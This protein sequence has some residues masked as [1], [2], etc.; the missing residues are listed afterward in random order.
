MKRILL[1]FIAVMALSL[2]TFA[3]LWITQNTNLAESRGITYMFSVNA[4]IVWAAAYDGVT[5]T[6]PCQDF[7]KTLDGGNTWTPGTITGATG[8][9]I[10]DMVAVDG[11]TCMG[12]LLSI[13]NRNASWGL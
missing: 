11:N 3:Q 9:C 6:A 5:P 1:S 2:G 4:N 8:L 7:A 10:A 12:I 13:G